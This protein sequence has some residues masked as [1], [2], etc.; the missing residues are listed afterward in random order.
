[1][2]PNL[3]KIQLAALAYLQKSEKYMVIKSDKILGPCLIEKTKYIELAYRDHLSDTSTYGQLST[4]LAKGRMNSI[5]IMLHN[6]IT[7]HHTYEEDKKIQYTDDG[8]YLKRTIE[9]NN[10]FARFYLLAKI[11]KE[12]L[13]T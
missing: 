7:T 12:P 3:T 10:D 4:T 8:T 5:R 11:H 13:K 1:M 6:F 2:G 9:A